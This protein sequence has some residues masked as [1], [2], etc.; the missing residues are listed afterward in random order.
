MSLSSS[1][2]LDGPVTIDVPATSANLG[3]GYDSFGLALSRFDRVTASVLDS[4]LEI[5]ATGEGSDQIP[6]DESHLIVR[7][8]RAAFEVLGA[9]PPGLRLECVNRIPHGRGL[10]SSA[11]AIV[12]GVELARSLVT[13]GRSRLADPQALALASELEGHPDNVAACLLGGLT[14]AWTANGVGQAARAEPVGILPVV[15]IPSEQ[16]ST[17][18]ARAALPAS[19]PHVDAAF[20]VARAALL[21][22]ALTGRSDL[23]MTAT[24]DRLHQDYRAA[25]VPTS[26]ALIE[27]L[28]AVEVPAVVSGAGSSVLALASTAPE[29][30]RAAGLCPVGW[31]VAE[32]SV[33]DGARLVTP[34]DSE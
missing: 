27:E 32:L 19:I 25:G 23:L 16:S 22:L 12:A 34:G 7:A 15:F 8:M 17:H 9:Q 29:V 26:M 1:A 33:A 6:T 11:A 3:P 5:R 10:G 4:G 2:F 30:K 20:N 28:R 24:E 18:A 31:Q 14:V 21:V 13:D